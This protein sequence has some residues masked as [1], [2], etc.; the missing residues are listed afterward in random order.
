MSKQKKWRRLAD[1]ETIQEGDRLTFG[2]GDKVTA[3]YLVGSTVAAFVNSPPWPGGYVERLVEKRP[4]FKKLVK[5][6]ESINK[7]ASIVV[8]CD[9]SGVIY[10]N[11]DKV[12]FSFWRLDDLYEYLA[13]LPEKG[14]SE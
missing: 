3:H 5:R 9:E 8:F 10:D 4:G 2:D 12:V 11:A 14:K 1:D 6:L 7:T 13:S